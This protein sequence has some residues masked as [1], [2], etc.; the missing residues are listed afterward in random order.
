[1][2]CY[3]MSMSQNLPPLEGAHG[4]AIELLSKP[5]DRHREGKWQAIPPPVYKA[6]VSDTLACS[7]LTRWMHGWLT[8]SFTQRFKH[9]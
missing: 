2:L 8:G 5:L 1:M 9:S 6:R 3:V 4:S 7:L